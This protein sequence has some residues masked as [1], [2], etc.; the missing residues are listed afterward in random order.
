MD[1]LAGAIGGIMEL[2]SPVLRPIPNELDLVAYQTG[3]SSRVPGLLASEGVGRPVDGGRLLEETDGHGVGPDH[4]VV[5]LKTAD[6][7]EN[8][9]DDTKHKDHW[10]AYD[11]EDQDETNQ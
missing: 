9:A 7:G 2:R 5:S 6:Y 1:G 10:N 3:D 4:A 11:H 8:R